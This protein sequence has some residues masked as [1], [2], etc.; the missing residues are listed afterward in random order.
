MTWSLKYS[1]NG[2]VLGG[3]RSFKFEKVSICLAHAH[4]SEAAFPTV[5]V[6]CAKTRLWHGIILVEG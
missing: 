2:A 5:P 6:R 4:C 1:S 3:G